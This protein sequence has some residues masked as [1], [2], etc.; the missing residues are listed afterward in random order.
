MHYLL[1]RPLSP[2]SW[3][4]G[5]WA[6]SSGTFKFNANVGQI[7]VSLENF[8]QGKSLYGSKQ[9]DPPHDIT[10]IKS[11]YIIC[12]SAPIQIVNFN[13]AYIG[14]FQDRPHSK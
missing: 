14:N 6:S 13:N 2:T 7:L 10:K 12:N 9:L 3:G 1:H 5:E 8:V 11:I 4:R